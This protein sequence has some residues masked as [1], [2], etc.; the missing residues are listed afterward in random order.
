MNK[1]KDEVRQLTEAELLE[2]EKKYQ[3]CKKPI[4]IA[5]HLFACATILYVFNMIFAKGAY[6]SVPQKKPITEQL[7]RYREHEAYNDYLT[8]IQKDATDKLTR[9]ELTVDEYKHILE[10]VKNDENFENFLRGLEDDG[11]VQKVVEEYDKYEKEL[12]TINKRYS[13]I[14]IVALSANLVSSL[15]LAKYRLRE[16]SI[17]EARKKRAEAME[18]G[19][20]EGT[21]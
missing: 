4:R 21:M 5:W 9:G 12:A 18:S 11:T 16:D 15:I 13:A 1:K 14:A 6:E 10:T 19:S 8:S 2:E 20:N 3:A 17:E 7:D